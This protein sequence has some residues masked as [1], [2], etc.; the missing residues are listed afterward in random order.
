MEL[1]LIVTVTEVVLSSLGGMFLGVTGYWVIENTQ[2]GQDH[3]FIS[4]GLVFFYV[5]M[6]VLGVRYVSILIQG[7][8]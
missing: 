3:P 4:G 1:S 5:L 7:A 6:F 2:F 8:I